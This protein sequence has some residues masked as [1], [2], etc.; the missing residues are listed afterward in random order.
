MEYMGTREV[1]TVFWWGDARKRDRLEDTDV[2]WG[3]KLK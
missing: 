3:T 1:Y 2:D